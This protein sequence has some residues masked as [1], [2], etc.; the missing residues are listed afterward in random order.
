MRLVFWFVCLFKQFL[1]CLLVYACVRVCV[2]VCVIL[3]P[4]VKSWNS[5]YWGLRLAAKHFRQNAFC[6]FFLDHNALLRYVA[7]CHFLYICVI[8]IVA[9]CGNCC[10]MFQ[11]LVDHNS[12]LQYVA[13]LYFGMCCS[14]LQC[15]LYGSRL[16][17]AVQ[18][19]WG[20]LHALEAHSSQQSGSKQ[21]HRYT[22]LLQERP[23]DIGVCYK[24]DLQKTCHFCK[25]RVFLQEKVS[26][27]KETCRNMALSR[28]LD[29]TAGKKECV[30][31]VER[32][33]ERELKKSV[34]YSGRKSEC[35]WFKSQLRLKCHLTPSEIQ[36]TER[37]TINE[38]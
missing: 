2:C 32:K 20:F 25:N 28:S 27:A 38:R 37:E 6:M 14:A 10:N 13:M 18:H 33:E 35:V 22:F 31:E 8:H 17:A 34:W 9:I 7:M 15:A 23:T 36:S 1:A 30:I 4:S 29:W 21:M 12:L 16:T 19:S 24:T 3:D 11:I 26:F 5:T